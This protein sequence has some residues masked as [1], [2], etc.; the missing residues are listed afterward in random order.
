MKNNIRKGIGTGQKVAGGWRLATGKKASKFGLRSS[1]FL[2]LTLALLFTSCED[3]VEVKLNDE[4]LN[5]VGV[6]ASITTLDGPTVFLYKTLKVDQDI[7]YP[8]ISGA[9]VSISD[10][11]SP[12]NSITLVEDQQKK[13]LYTVPQN[14]SFLGVAGREY[15]LNIQSEGT[16]ITAK[17]KLARVE[18]IDSIQ[19][20][21][22]M[23]GNKIFLA[24]FTYGKET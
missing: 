1:V 10:D 14:S 4:N 8:G 11:S 7:A 5:L 19:V 22:S 23:R 15:T 20:F 2:L 21:P 17:D 12:V 3:V 16:T 24:V 9:V 18:P 13:G 6:E